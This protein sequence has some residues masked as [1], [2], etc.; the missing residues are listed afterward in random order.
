MDPA[1]PHAGLCW[2]CGIKR[3][4]GTGEVEPARGLLYRAA[5]SCPVERNHCLDRRPWHRHAEDPPCRKPHWH[6]LPATG[7]RPEKCRRDLR[8]CTL[9][10]L[11]TATAA[12]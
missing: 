8:P 4:D 9:F 11:G 7:G 5:G 6:L 12:D 2:R 10:L 1:T 3:G